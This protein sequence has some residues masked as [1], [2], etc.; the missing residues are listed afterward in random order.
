MTSTSGGW[1]DANTRSPGRDIVFPSLR[2]YR[3]HQ[4]SGQI[5]VSDGRQPGTGA[6]GGLW[7]TTGGCSVPG[8]QSEWSAKAPWRC[9]DIDER[10]V[11]HERGDFGVSAVISRRWLTTV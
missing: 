7:T 9:W 11:Y 6:A 1:P 3:P 2:P 4:E 8:F 10:R 5:R